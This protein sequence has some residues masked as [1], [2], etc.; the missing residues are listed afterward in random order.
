MGSLRAWRL[1]DFAEVINIPQKTNAVAFSPDGQLIAAAESS[2]SSN[3]VKLWRSADGTLVRELYDAYGIAKSTL[4]FSPDGQFLAG[5]A[6]AANGV[7]IW[8][9][10][11]GVLVQTLPTFITVYS[12]DFAA[13]GLVLVGGRAGLNGVVQ[14]WRADG[15]F[16]REPHF[17]PGV[18]RAVRVA[19]DGLTA[20]GAG[21]DGVL[22]FWRLADGAL[23]KSYDK[24]VRG[25]VQL[26]MFGTLSLAYSRD[27]RL[28]VFGRGDGTAVTILNPWFAASPLKHA[29][30]TS[31][32]EPLEIQVGTPLGGDQLNAHADVPGTFAYYPPLGT[33]LPIGT[34]R[35][36]AVF[37]PADASASNRATA[38]TFL[39]IRPR[40][41]ALAQA[42][43]ASSAAGTTSPAM[44]V[45]ADGSSAW[46]APAQ[47]TAWLLVDLGAQRRIR[48]VRI[49]WGGKPA[50]IYAVAVSADLQNFTTVSVTTA[51]SGC[52]DDIGGLNVQTRFVLLYLPLT[53]RRG[54]SV[55]EVQV[56]G[57]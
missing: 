7:S 42:V 31:W 13:G 12:V 43:Y 51:G 32:N 17:Q 20:A 6:N 54:V 55:A 34:Y 8:R 15:T 18:M 5:A 26:N 44:V 25:Q 24:E 27:G 57:Q 52:P 1:A 9:V 50:P 28:L 56:F 22:R 23:I 33:V 10:S 29:P 46:E 45:D 53:T 47:S 36:T 11:D 2:G 48:H 19:P 4:S 40:N 3:A 41:V 39:T 49:V 14:L 38:S 21:D 37:T 35:L 30:V 16:L